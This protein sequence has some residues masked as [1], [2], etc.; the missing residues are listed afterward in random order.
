[1]LDRAHRQALLDGALLTV[2]QLPVVDAHTITRPGRALFGQVTDFAY[3][4]DTHH[5]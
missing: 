4:V 3:P 2:Q 5:P 1:M